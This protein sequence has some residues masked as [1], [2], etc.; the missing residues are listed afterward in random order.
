MSEPEP[1]PPVRYA[2][3]TGDG[4]GDIVLS[5]VSAGLFLYVGYVLLGGT[6]DPVYVGSIK[7]LKWGACV[8]GVGIL[9]T[10]GMTLARIPGAALLDVA[11]SAL[12]PALCLVVGVIWLIFS[13]TD[14]ILLLLFALLNGGATRSAW[15]RWRRQRPPSE[16]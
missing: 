6:G 1:N 8:V 4:G 12:A 15:Y 13:D 5:L 16:R 9:L 10:L 7:A 11:I 3:A 2:R 14:G